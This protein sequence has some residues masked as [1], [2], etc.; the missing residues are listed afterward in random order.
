VWGEPRIW[1]TGSYLSNPGHDGWILERSETNNTGFTKDNTDSGPSALRIGDSAS[2]HKQYKS[3]VS[4]D[5]SSITTAKT[6]VQAKLR[7]YCGDIV[8]EQISELGNVKVELKSEG[9]YQ[10]G[11]TAQ[12]PYEDLHTSDF[13]AP[14]DAVMAPVSAMPSVDSWYEIPL[15]ATVLPFI[16]RSGYT[17]IRLSFFVDDDNDVPS[18]DDYVGFFSG[19][20]GPPNDVLRPIL[21]V[22]LE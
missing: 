14:A 12:P 21:E 5:T 9:F 17:Q 16:N 18:S 3:I 4:F 13:Q 19:N 8:G 1:S 15:D 7:V 20:S 2:L 11:S 10:P 6:V 22:T